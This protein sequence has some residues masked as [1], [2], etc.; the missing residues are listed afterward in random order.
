MFY[1]DKF[2]ILQCFQLCFDCYSFYCF[3]NLSICRFQYCF[4][5]TCEM[6]QQHIAWQHFFVKIIFKKQFAKNFEIFVFIPIA[7]KALLVI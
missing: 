6:K 1:L 3:L 5:L 4:G 7:S 2:P